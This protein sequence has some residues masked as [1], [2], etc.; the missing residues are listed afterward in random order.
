[1]C[2]LMAHRSGQRLVWGWG[3]F[4]G[5]GDFL[6]ASTGDRC[7]LKEEM[8]ILA[9]KEEP[10]HGVWEECVSGPCTTATRRTR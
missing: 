10:V 6:L 9:Q 7:G 5:G 1:M 4:W 3:D 2:L 8:R